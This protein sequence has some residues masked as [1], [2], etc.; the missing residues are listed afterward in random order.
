MSKITVSMPNVHWGAPDDPSPS[1]QNR[2]Q[3][4][5]WFLSRREEGVRARVSE[6][7][8]LGERTIVVSLLVGTTQ[9]ADETIAEVERWQ[10]LTVAGDRVVDIRRFDDRAEAF[11]RTE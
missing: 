2:E 5:A 3:V 8:V 7:T 9:A 1:C 10:V 4:L 6:V 11:A